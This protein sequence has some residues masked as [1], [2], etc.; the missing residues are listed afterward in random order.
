[1]NGEFRAVILDDY[2]P[3]IKLPNNTILPA[4][5]KPYGNELWVLLLEKAWAKLA[6]GYNRIE[7]GFCH[8]VFRVLTGAP[9][10]VILTSDQNFWEKFKD[11]INSNFL[12]TAS[13]KKKFTMQTY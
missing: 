8:E 11:G 1:M 6:G 5:T 9:T 12:L 3:A 7:S 4:F 2:F 13:V 10:K